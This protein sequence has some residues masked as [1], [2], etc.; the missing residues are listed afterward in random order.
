L[1]CLPAFFFLYKTISPS[2]LLFQQCLRTKPLFTRT[3]GG[4]AE[5]EESSI[6]IH[7]LNLI[8]GI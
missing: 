6:S 1:F 7:R 4:H 8:T 2:I 3:G 5:N